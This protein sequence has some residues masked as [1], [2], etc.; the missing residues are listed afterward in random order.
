MFHKREEG[1]PIKIGINWNRSLYT[2]FY[3]GLALPIW[4]T[5]NHR[6][7]EFDTGDLVCSKLIKV[8]HFGVRINKRWKIFWRWH[9]YKQV[10]GYKQI[11]KTEEELESEGLHC[12]N[13]G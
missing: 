10:F 12:W 8:L 7:R 6:Y 1:E 5:S 11:I 2:K 3:I 9:I 13:S 4:I